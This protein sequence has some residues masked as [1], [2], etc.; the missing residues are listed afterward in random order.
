MSKETLRIDAIKKLLISQ[1]IETN[2]LEKKVLDLKKEAD[3]LAIQLEMKLKSNEQLR[4][5]L[6]LLGANL[7]EEN[8]SFKHSDNWN[9][10]AESTF[11]IISEKGI[12]RGVEAKNIIEEYAKHGILAHPRNIFDHVNILEKE[13]KIYQINPDQKRGRKFKTK[14]NLS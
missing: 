7:K 11:K 9:L 12:P 3:F 14:E 5:E 13:N 8:V 6:Q 4:S 10:S 2:E 1:E